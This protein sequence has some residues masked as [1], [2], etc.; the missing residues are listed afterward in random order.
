V[1]AM[2]CSTRWRSDQREAARKSTIVRII[3][4]AAAQL[5]TERAR[6]REESP[7]VWRLI[8]PGEPYAL[9]SAGHRGS[10]AHLAP[11][12]RRSG[13]ETGARLKLSTARD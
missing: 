10:A 5:S 13:G 7:R 2:A 11:S 9:A 4:I 1:P 3:V 8:E 6:M 12:A